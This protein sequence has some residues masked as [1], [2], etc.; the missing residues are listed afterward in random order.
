MNKKAEKSKLS[1][2]EVIAQVVQRKKDDMKKER[3]K[4]MMMLKGE[5][6]FQEE[7]KFD[8]LDK[9]KTEFIMDMLKQMSSKQ[10]RNNE[11]IERIENQSMDIV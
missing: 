8:G 1:F 4:K 3:K 7:I 9:P 5:G 11:L 2:K 10:A 6:A